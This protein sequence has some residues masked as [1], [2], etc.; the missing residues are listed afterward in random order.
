MKYL[1]LF[2]VIISLHAGLAEAA[3]IS[4]RKIDPLVAG[5]QSFEVVL[6]P[7]GESINALAGSISFPSNLFD[8][9]S[10]STIGSV[11][12]LWITSPTFVNE[13]NILNSRSQIAFEGVMPGGFSGVRSPYYKGMHPGVLFTFT[14]DPKASGEALLLPE[15]IDV[16]LNDGAGTKIPVRTDDL[17][18]YIAQSQIS[19]KKNNSSIINTTIN[20]EAKEHTLDAYVTHDEGVDNDKWILVIEDDATRHTILSYKVAESTSYEDTDVNFYEWREATSPYILTSQSRNR[21]IHVKAIYADGTYNTIIISPVE[22]ISDDS[23]TWRILVSIVIGLLCVYALYKKN[24]Q[25][26]SSSHSQ[27]H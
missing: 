24:A 14:L 2:F 25:R 3:S 22:N 4:I 21:F 11:V 10:I 15:N 16:R 20:T 12:S 9:N 6:D 19:S 7:E 27:V 5:A 13:F 1:L 18:L 26:S 23:N 17:T 8:P